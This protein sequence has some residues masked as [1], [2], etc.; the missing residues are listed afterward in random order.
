VKKRVVGVLVGV[1]GLPIALYVGILLLLFLAQDALVFPRPTASKDQL[2]ALAARLGATELVLE[3]EAGRYYGWHYPAAGDRAILYFHGNGE[4]VASSYELAHVAVRQGFDFFV[5][6]YPGYPGSDGSPN[7]ASIGSTARVAWHHVAERFGASGVLLHGRSLGGGAVGTLL[8]EARPAG[9]VLESTFTRLVDVAAEHYP[10]FPVRALLR[11]R[12]A[13]IERAPTVTD[14]PVLIF[15]GDA[16]RTIPVS[17]GRALAKSFP[18]A[19]YIEAPGWGHNDDML[20]NDAKL[21][22]AW[23]RFLQ[24]A[25]PPGDET[26]R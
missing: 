22:D 19:Q 24:R 23:K 8:D 15:H 2:A 9:I 16:D 3:G 20:M 12:F 18:T 1:V 14:L 25:A 13:T 17:H 21:L 11:H 4:S 10:Y 6:A 7:E 26:P 5:F